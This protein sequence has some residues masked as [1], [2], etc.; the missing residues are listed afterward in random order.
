ERAETQ[1]VHADGTAPSEDEWKS[2]RVIVEQVLPA[3][4]AAA[5]PPPALAKSSG[6]TV[7]LTLVRWPYT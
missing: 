7:N 1:T 5:L 2:A 3:Y 4:E 6:K